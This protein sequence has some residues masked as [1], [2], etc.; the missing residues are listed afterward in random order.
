LFIRGFIKSVIFKNFHIGKLGEWAEKM[1]NVFAVKGH[2][3]EGSQLAKLRKAF[4]HFSQS[5]D[6]IVRFA[7][8][9]YPLQHGL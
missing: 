8:V 3:E 5:R 6:F 9:G 1:L 7:P 4:P 2:A